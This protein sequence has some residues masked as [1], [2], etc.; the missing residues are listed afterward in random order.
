MIL[1][2][3][4]SMTLG[5]LVESGIVIEGYRKIQCWES[6]SNPT[7]YHEGNHCGNLEEYY[8][9]EVAYI[10]PYNPIPGEAGICIELAD[11]K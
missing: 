5:A 7:I 1:R 6:E 9:R 8:D 3:G 4:V 10:F 11:E 2:E